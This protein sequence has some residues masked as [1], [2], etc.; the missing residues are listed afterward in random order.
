MPLKNLCLHY[1]FSH[2]FLKE[3]KSGVAATVT[4]S[5]DKSTFLKLAS[6]CMPYKRRKNV[7]KDHIS[8]D[9]AGTL[10]MGASHGLLS[11]SSERG[12][13]KSQFSP[14]NGGYHLGNSWLCAQT[15]RNAANGLNE[16][17]LGEYSDMQANKERCQSFDINHMS[18]G[19]CKFSSSLNLHDHRS[20]NFRS[21]LAVN[22]FSAPTVQ[23][24]DIFPCR[25]Q[26]SSFVQ[27]QPRQVESSTDSC[28]G[29]AIHA[30]LSWPNYVMPYHSR[31]KS[32]R[33]MSYP[34]TEVI[35]ISEQLLSA[36]LLTEKP[37]LSS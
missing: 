34:V 4:S 12:S 36:P 11:V 8:L 1:F 30:E 20:Q 27:T 24:C 15:A 23:T 29:T 25:E 17:A 37:R 26:S 32:N 2:Q 18:M 21:V 7:L 28:S 22:D 10:D 5:K 13:D 9:Q 14:Y 16:T 31:E 33:T 19:S 3:R 35:P 6:K